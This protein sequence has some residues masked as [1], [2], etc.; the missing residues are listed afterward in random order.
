M[1]VK[2]N[3]DNKNVAHILK[4]GSKTPDLQHIAVD[5]LQ[6]CEH[7]SI[8]LVP[9]WLPRTANILADSLSRIV[10]HDDW[11][12]KHCIFL[13]FNKTWGPYTID[14]FASHYNTQCTRFNSL[15]WYPGT[16]AVDAFSQIWSGEN[17]WLVPPPS[18]IPRTINKMRSDKAVGTLIIPEW[19]SAPFWPLVCTR[20]IF[21]S[22]IKEFRYL[23]NTKVI[24]RGAGKNCIF[25]PWPLKFRLLAF[26]IEF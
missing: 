13:E 18:L 3:T 9:N 14:R 24:I 2:L 23:P 12:L 25:G 15:V 17:N 10:D 11:G 16:E 26:R 20:G 7:N 21:A 22:F 5:I 19:I 6:M 1:K 4:V 8:I